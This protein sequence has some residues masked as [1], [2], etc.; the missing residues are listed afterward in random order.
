VAVDGC[1]HLVE[2]R[3]QL[4]G[5]LL[6]APDPAH[7]GQRRAR[8]RAFEQ[9]RPR[10]CRAV[11]GAG[12]L[13]RAGTVAVDVAVAGSVAVPLP[14]QPVHVRHDPLQLL[15][16]AQ[17]LGLDLGIE[18]AERRVVRVEPRYRR[19]KQLL[20]LAGAHELVARR[21]VQPGGVLRTADWVSARDGRIT[22]GE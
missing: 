10:R 8:G 18:P 13:D 11:G 19:V 6:V 14:H 1:V 17:Y 15:E 12:A 22:E 3:Q 16:Q 20:E 21:D 4:L 2:L 5:A 9:R 7:L